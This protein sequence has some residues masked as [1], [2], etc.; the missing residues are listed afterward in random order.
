MSTGPIVESLGRRLINIKLVVVV[1]GLDGCFY[2]G[3]A[4]GALDPSQD[5]DYRQGIG[6]LDGQYAACDGRNETYLESESWGPIRP[7]K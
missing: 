4:L 5:G 7:Q 2:C 1:L 6:S 3:L